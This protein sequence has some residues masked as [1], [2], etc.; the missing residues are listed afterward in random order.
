MSNPVARFIRR[1]EW[2]FRTLFKGDDGSLNEAAKVA[3]ADLRAFC[4]GT[5]SNFSK[6][7]L[8]MA[9]MEGRREV[10]TRV[11]NYLEVDYSKYYQME[12]QIDD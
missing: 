10:F 5:Q 8:E 2:A 7:A 11:M 12:E 4:H 9:R 6:D 1:K 3:L